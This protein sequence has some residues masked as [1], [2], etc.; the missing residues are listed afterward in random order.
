MIEYLFP[1]Y[2]INRRIDIQKLYLA[3]IKKIL[4]IK[5]PNIDNI[6]NYYY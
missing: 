6:I 3:Y 4:I 5:I 2:L 1:V